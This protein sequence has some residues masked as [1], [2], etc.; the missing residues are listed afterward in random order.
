MY[1][2]YQQRSSAWLKFMEAMNNLSATAVPPRICM[3]AHTH[4]DH[5]VTWLQRLQQLHDLRAHLLEQQRNVELLLL[6][7]F[8][9]P[10]K[11]YISFYLWTV[12]E[13]QA[14]APK[15][16]GSSF[17]QWARSVPN[18]QTECFLSSK[19]A[20]TASFAPVGH[21]DLSDW[22][23]RWGT[24][25]ASAT[26]RALALGSARSFD[27][28]GTTERLDETNLLVARRLNW[29]VHDAA[30]PPHMAMATP[31]AGE[32][33]MNKMVRFDDRKMW[34]CRVHGRDPKAE[35]RR[36]H[37]RVCPDMAK[38]AQLIRE[39]APV[40]HELYE[41]ATQRLDAAVAAA[42]A[43]F[44]T[45]LTEL[46][47]L[48]KLGRMLEVVAKQERPATCRWATIITKDGGNLIGGPPLERNERRKLWSNAPN[49]STAPADRACVPGDNTVMRIVWG[50]HRLGGKIATNWPAGN[51]IAMG[52]GHR[53]RNAKAR[54]GGRGRGS[55]RGGISYAAHPYLERHRLHDRQRMLDHQPPTYARV[56]KF[57]GAKAQG[58]PHA[59]PTW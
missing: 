15:R 23:A 10:L 43:K 29:T 44:Q 34:W 31:L 22:M 18:L 39:I 1:W 13:R 54:G 7:R 52:G 53:K 4:I 55:G 17:E 25:N 56:R 26:R 24:P 51:L 12:V 46:R 28:I 33:C 2:G 20:F 8:R 41:L 5:G 35:Q 57:F 47:R 11:H 50:E 42:G 21:R 37:A 16:F 48:N 45:D 19:S 14:R 27:V 30:P 40:D 49:F 36:V 38:C 3:E 9:Q 32:T 58:Q 59:V 6:L